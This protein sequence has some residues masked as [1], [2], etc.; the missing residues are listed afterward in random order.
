MTFRLKR[1][2]WL[3]GM[4]AAAVADPPLV[5]AS[6]ARPLVTDP[7][8]ILDLPPGF[9][10]RVIS[11]V[12]AKMHDGYRVPGHFDAMGLFEHDGQLVLMRNHEVAPGEV[13]MGPYA[14]GV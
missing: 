10:Y 12:G 5:A 8:G 3:Q 13:A 11:R 6:R 7:K 14:P 1:R 2:Q 9:S 4:A